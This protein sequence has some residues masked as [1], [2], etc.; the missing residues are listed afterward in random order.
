M[1]GEAI[2]PFI[3]RRIG[4]TF[5]VEATRTGRD[6]VNALVRI[7]RGPELEIESAISSLVG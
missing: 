4:S 3:D 5:F 7:Y 2:Q 1:I 6:S